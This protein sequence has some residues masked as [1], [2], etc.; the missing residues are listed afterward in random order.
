MSR[1]IS[2]N[3]EQWVEAA[4]AR[5]TTERVQWDMA[6]QMTSGGPQVAMAF[7][8]PSAVLG[9]MLQTGLL[10]Q[11]VVAATQAECESAVRDVIEQ[12]HQMRS[13]SLSASSVGQQTLFPLGTS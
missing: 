8:M 10:L 4:I 6:F 5:F 2:T 12:L 3:I 9:E 7:F 1:R 13:E 11:N